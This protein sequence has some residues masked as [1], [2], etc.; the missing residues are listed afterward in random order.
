MPDEILSLA[1]YLASSRAEFALSEMNQYLSR[2]Y[3][4]KELYELLKPHFYDLDLFCGADYKCTKL[5]KQPL[6]ADE[7]VIRELEAQFKNPQLPARVEKLIGSYI[8]RACGKNWD[9]GETAQ[10]IRDNIVK[11]KEEYWTA[12]GGSQYPKIRIISYLL[13]HFP[14]YFC[15]YQYLL[16]E[17]LQKGLLFNKMRI[18]D[19]GSGPGTITLGTMDFFL[20]LLESYS[21]NGMDVKLNIRFDSIEQAQENIDCYKDLTSGYLSGFP[22]GNAGIIINEPVHAS[23]SAIEP[24]RVP[25]EAD[26]IIFSNVL[27]E[28]KLAPARRADAVERLA[29]LSKNPTVIIIE[30]ADLDN[31]KALRVTQHALIK[32]GFTVY[33]PCTFIWGTGCSGDNCWSFREPGN[34]QAPGFMERIARTGESYRYLNTDMKFSY[35]ILRKDGLTLRSYQAKG[36]FMRLSNL[37]KHIGK[38]INVAASVMSGNL[39]DGETFVFKVCDGTTSTPCYAVLPAYHISDN[40]RTLFEAGYGGIVEIYGALVRENKALSSYNLL[41]TR[42][43]RV[44]PVT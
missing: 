29:S 2:K 21:K 24:A 6:P 27:A 12:G 22:P 15:Q 25:E 18:L 8:E 43:T 17:L 10:L 20:K 34:I 31:S 19:V 32:K 28:M 9:T 4:E 33:S 5:V 11:Q 37:K 35:A 42:N 16:L 14:V 30:P 1:K 41:I 36:K 7:T 3:E 44:E 26:L 13:Y 39:G 38:R 23:V 40:N